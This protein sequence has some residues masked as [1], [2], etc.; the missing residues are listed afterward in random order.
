MAPGVFLEAEFAVTK[1][2]P[3]ITQIYDTGKRNFSFRS[4]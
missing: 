3:Q 4:S 2:C 1:D